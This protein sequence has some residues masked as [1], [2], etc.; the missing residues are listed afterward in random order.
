MRVSGSIVLCVLVARY[1][2][3]LCVLVASTAEAG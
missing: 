3:W 1:G 2:A